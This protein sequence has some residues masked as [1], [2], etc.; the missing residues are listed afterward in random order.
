MPFYQMRQLMA[1]QLNPINRTRPLLELDRAVRN[2]VDNLGDKLVVRGNLGVPGQDKVAND[3]CQN[4][5]DVLVRLGAAGQR[6][7]L[8]LPGTRQRQACRR[9][10]WT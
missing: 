1:E 7:Q 8:L 4:G 5:V 3:N 9:G 6:R 10:R 2:N